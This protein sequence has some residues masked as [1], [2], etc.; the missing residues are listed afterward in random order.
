MSIRTAALAGAFMVL[1]GCTSDVTPILNCVAADNLKPDCRF[2]N[3]EDLAAT[4]GGVWLLVSQFGA[5]DGSRPGSIAGYRPDIGTIEELYPVGE[6]E[7]VRTW[8]EA[9]CAP[10]DAASFAP[11]GIDLETRDDGTL[12]LLVVNHGSRESIEFFAVEE[13]NAGLGLAWRGCAMGPQ[14]AYFND[15]V[16]RR[17]GGFWVTHMMP[18]SSQL[19]SP[20]KGALLGSDTGFVYGWSAAGGF[21]RVPG[22]DAP[23]PNGIEK[24]ADERFIYVNSYLG[25][26]VRKIDVATGEVVARAAASNPDNL[27][28]A[29]DGRLLVASHTDSIGEFLACGDLTEGACGFAFEIL[30]LDADTLQGFA[31]LAHRGAPMGGATV[32]VQLGDSLYLG[33]FAGDRI[34]RWH[35]PEVP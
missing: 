27:S 31:W 18:Q 33:S 20:L 3:P 28:W 32:A 22:T 8:G 30:A 11:H 24:S 14:D 29:A 12:M 16:A 5:M 35:I 15:V 26:E 34:T 25:G 23:M 7:D 21:Q 4:P 1:A 6:M 9:S 17:D 19:W 2:Q 10:P 13:S